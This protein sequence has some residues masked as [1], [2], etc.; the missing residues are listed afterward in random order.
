MKRK[1]QFISAA[2][3]PKCSSEDTLVLYSDDQSIACVNCNF[4]QTSEQRDKKSKIKENEQATTNSD[5]LS[6]K[7]TQL[8][9]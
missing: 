6:I 4:E 7:I 1:K 5:K 2:I 3:C 8:D 9:S